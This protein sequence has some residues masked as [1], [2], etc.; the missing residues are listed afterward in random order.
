MV[1]E[2]ASLPLPACCSFL[3]KTNGPPEFHSTYFLS[4]ELLMAVG[5][6]NLSTL[7]EGLGLVDLRCCLAISV[8]FPTFGTESRPNRRE[9]YHDRTPLRTWAPS[10]GGEQ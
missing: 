4:L 6:G 1:F 8:A 10:H 2:V 9:K 7:D 5:C 3:L